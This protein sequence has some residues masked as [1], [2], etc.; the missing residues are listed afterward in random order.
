[1][2]P[3]SVSVDPFLAFYLM[4]SG[5]GGNIARF[6]ILPIFR[7]NE[8]FWR[9]HW[10]PHKDK[11]EKVDTYLRVVREIMLENSELQDRNDIS[12]YDRFEFLKEL[13]GLKS[14]KEY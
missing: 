3:N 12:Y 14:H 10:E 8:Y 13:N 6:K 11:E 1:M 7:P 2:T 4:C 9:T 5:K